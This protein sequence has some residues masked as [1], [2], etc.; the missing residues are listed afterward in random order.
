LD[1][2][3]RSGLARPASGIWALADAAWP[4]GQNSGI[5]QKKLG[6]SD[7][8]L[9]DSTIV[10]AHKAAAGASGGQEKHGIG[11]SRGCLTTKIH[12][13]LDERGVPLAVD[14]AA[15]QI[16]DFARADELA[17]ANSCTQLLAGRG[18]D[19]DHFRNML[20]AKGIRPI[21]PGRGR[22]KNAFPLDHETYKKLNIVELFFV[23]IKEFRR[24]A[25]RYEKTLANFRA[26][27]LF[28]CI[29]TLLQ[30]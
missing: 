20:F 25:T 3:D 23:R 13:T 30:H 8:H 2:A 6:F 9:I 29:V 28:G 19:S 7:T 21:I 10:K 4:L 26:M 22:R 17:E 12:M 18:Y 16:S 11:R 1:A 15:G 5:A 27:F 24:I 14:F